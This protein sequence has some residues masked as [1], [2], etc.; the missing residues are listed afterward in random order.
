MIFISLCNYHTIQLK[1]MNM[2]G[3]FT[4]VIGNCVQ[5][6]LYSNNIDKKLQSG[7]LCLNEAHNLSLSKRC[8]EQICLLFK[9]VLRALCCFSSIVE[10]FFVWEFLSLC[11]NNSWQKKIPR[12]IRM[13]KT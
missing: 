9:F 1:L 3:K 13:N 6:V 4:E 7:F 5:E 12:E 2:E 10:L 8:Q 11:K